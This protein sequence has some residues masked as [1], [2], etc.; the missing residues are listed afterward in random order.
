M[1]EILQEQPERFF[2]LGILKQICSNALANKIS[3]LL[4]T[5]DLSPA[6]PDVMA[7]CQKKLFEGYM[8]ICFFD[9]V[10]RLYQVGFSGCCCRK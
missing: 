3:S 6:A 9:Y 7:I 4:K 8:D 5:L 10:A 2:E 1:N